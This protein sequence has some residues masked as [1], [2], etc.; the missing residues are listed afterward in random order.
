MA[1]LMHCSIKEVMDD[2]LGKAAAFAREN[3]LI[4]VLKDVVTVITDGERVWL[5]HTGCSG[6]ATGG[7]GDVL[8]GTIAGVAAQG[9]AP[10]N[11]AAAG[12]WIHGTAG[13]NA[14]RRIGDHGMLASD[15]IR[16]LPDTIRQLYDT[17]TKRI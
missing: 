1:R 15:I 2:P 6:M 3:K 10:F 9:M 17:R 12:V 16:E 4:C 13:T 11:A 14:A 5:C 7:S 8:A